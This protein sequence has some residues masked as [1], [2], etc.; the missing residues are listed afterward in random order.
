MTTALVDILFKE[1]RRK[2][3]GLLLLNPLQAYHVR[4][5]ARLTGTVAGTI[6]KELKKLAE[7]GVL[8]AQKTGNQLYY[9]ANQRCPVFDELVG[10]IRKTSGLADVLRLALSAFADRIHVAFVFGSV[11]SG[12]ANNQSDIDLCVVGDVDFVEVVEAVYDCQQILGREI[13][14]KCFSL[15]EWQQ[16]QLD[17]TVFIDEL[18]NKPVINVIGNRDDVI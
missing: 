12:V 14:P 2:V 10:L 9:Q 7:A 15:T 6:N 8:T 1:Q 4:E 3:L 13:N 16:A 11:A 18:M 5:I 17:K